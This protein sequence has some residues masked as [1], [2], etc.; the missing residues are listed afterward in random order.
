MITRSECL[1][2]KSWT[3]EKVFFTQFDVCGCFSQVESILWAD[4]RC[5][6]FAFLSQVVVFSR[7][8]SVH[9]NREL[10]GLKMRVRSFQVVA[11]TGLT[12]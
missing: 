3:I 4:F 2:R 5:P 7:M 12:V 11:R 10:K 8:H 6:R 9:L 1:R